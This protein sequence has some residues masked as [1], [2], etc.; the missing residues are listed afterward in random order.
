MLNAKMDI[1]DLEVGFQMQPPAVAMHKEAH[2]G[3]EAVSWVSGRRRGQPM[4]GSNVSP[5]DG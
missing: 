5:L 4:T 3:A 2:C 1:L